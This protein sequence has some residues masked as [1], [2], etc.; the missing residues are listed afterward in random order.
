MELHKQNWTTKALEKIE[1]ANE[2]QKYH[3]NTGN[4]GSCS[5]W[6]VYMKSLIPDP[7]VPSTNPSSSRVSP[8]KSNSPLHFSLQQV[9]SPSRRPFEGTPQS[10]GAPAA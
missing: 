1:D 6:P 4:K 5:P 7:T 8:N 2:K 3:I 9:A 10:A